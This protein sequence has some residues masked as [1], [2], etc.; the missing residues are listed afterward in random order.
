M[1]ALDPAVPPQL[2]EIVD[3]QEEMLEETE[4]DALIFDTC[5]SCLTVS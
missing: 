3:D 5:T 2:Q 1:E 4:D